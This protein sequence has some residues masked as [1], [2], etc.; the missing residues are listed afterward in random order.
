MVYNP[1]NIYLEFILYNQFCRIFL[2][3]KLKRLNKKS[4]KKQ[5]DPLVYLQ[6]I[7]ISYTSISLID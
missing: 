6:F 5:M 4:K 7:I 1:C 3:S 2:P